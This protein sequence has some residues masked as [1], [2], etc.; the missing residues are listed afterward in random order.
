MRVWL[1]VLG[2]LLLGGCAIQQATPLSSEEATR[3]ARANTDIA[4]HHLRNDALE[5]A[6]E[7]IERALHQDPELIDAHLVAAELQERLNESAVAETHFQ[8]ALS[9]DSDN[10]PA[11]NNYAAF[12]CGRGQL[13]RALDLWDMAAANPLYRGRIMAL[14][15]AARC[16]AVSDQRRR[17]ASYWRRALALQ[18]DYPPA[19][20]GMAEWS[21][22]HDRINAAQHWFSRYTAAAEESPSMLWL[23]VRIARAADHAERHGQLARRLRERYPASEQAARLTE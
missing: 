7:K 10:G 2:A 13:R 23:G 6:L 15:N 21:L 17:A 5:P 20:R 11:L 9:L 12:L 14:S 1:T 16:L 3:A 4:T 19:L 8:R 22:A 18:S